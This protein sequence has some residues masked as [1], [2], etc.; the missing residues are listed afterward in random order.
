M[1]NNQ[2]VNLRQTILLGGLTFLLMLPETLPVPVLRDLVA[3]TTED[4]EAASLKIVAMHLGL[5]ADAEDLLGAWQER[6]PA[7][8]KRAG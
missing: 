4:L 7:A 8:K 3:G 2:A 6:Q 1:A 5:V